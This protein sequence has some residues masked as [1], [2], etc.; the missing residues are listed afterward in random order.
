MKELMAH[1]T[2]PVILVYNIVAL[3]IAAVA[4]TILKR[5]GPVIP[6]I[7]TLAVA[8]SMLAASIGVGCMYLSPAFT[9]PDGMVAIIWFRL[10]GPLGVVGAVS[11]GVLIKRTIGTKK[12]R[13]SA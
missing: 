2:T 11:T 5:K 9:H 6:S 7:V 3:L 8:A 13:T 10:A 4:V 12:M 1:L